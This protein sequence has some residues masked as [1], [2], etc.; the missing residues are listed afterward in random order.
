[1]LSRRWARLGRGGLTVEVALLFCFYLSVTC[2]SLSLR[3]MD[4]SQT[5]SLCSL[6]LP[7]NLGL[8]PAQETTASLGESYQVPGELMEGRAPSVCHIIYN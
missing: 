7:P 5:S 6:P 8:L 4:L 1:M 2:I 3:Q